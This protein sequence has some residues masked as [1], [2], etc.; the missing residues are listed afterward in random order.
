MQFAKAKEETDKQVLY[1]TSI[2]NFAEFKSNIINIVQKGCVG[3]TI[4]I[5]QISKL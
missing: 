2:I 1:K 3:S 4:F 5:S